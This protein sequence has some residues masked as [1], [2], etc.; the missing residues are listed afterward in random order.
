MKLFALAALAASVLVVTQPAAAAPATAT[1][2]IVTTSVVT[3][4]ARTAGANLFLDLIETGTFTGTLTGTFVADATVIIHASGEA[5]FHGRVVFTG[6]V[7]GC[8]A[9]TLVFHLEGQG[10]GPV[11]EGTFGTLTGQGSLP[12]HLEGSFTQVGVLATYDGQYHC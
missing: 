7:A 1:G 10:V 11:N 9:G 3:T 12:V 6:A 2:T 8:G 4:G 5:E